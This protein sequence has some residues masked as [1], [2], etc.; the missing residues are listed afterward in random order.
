M[1][2]KKTDITQPNDAQAWRAVYICSAARCGSTFTDMFLGGHSRAASLGEINFLGKE[3][4]QNQACACGA[5]V[6]DCGHW[7]RVF[8]ELAML[9]GLDMRAQ[10]YAFHLW[11]ALAWNGVDTR[12]QTP[13]FKLAVYLRKTWLELRR[14]SGNRLPLLSSQVL[15]LRNKIMLYE[16]VARQWSKQVVIDSSKNAREAAE[17]N[18]LM[19]GRVKVVL[20]TRDGRGAYLSRRFAH[21]SRRESLYGWMNY[22]RR[23]L[24]L[25]EKQIKPGDLMILRYEDLAADPEN[26][27]RRLC[28]FVGLDFE[29]GMLDLATTTRHIVNGND[30]RFSAGK[31]IR[32]DERWREALVGNDHSYFERNG[33]KMNERLGYS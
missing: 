24:P 10:P 1:L 17:L 27:G 5:A 12:R 26:A 3:I 11:D 21:R 4:A 33:S 30:T 8:D 7:G 9:T 25:L 13:A 31:G 15:G 28:E 6:K 19:P 32:L 2:G 22:Y 14:R 20:V 23:A 16:T 29:A 18:R